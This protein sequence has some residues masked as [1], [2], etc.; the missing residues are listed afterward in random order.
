[1]LQLLSL[2]NYRN[3]HGEWQLQ[4]GANLIIAPN[5]SGKSNLIE[6]IFLLDTNRLLR[7]AEDQSAVIGPKA[8]YTRIRAE[9][10]TFALEMSLT[11]GGNLTKVVKL[12]D[13]KTTPAKLRGKLAS[14]LFAPHSVDLIS[15][16]PAVRRDDLDLFLA[17]SDHHFL[18]ISTKYTKILRNR[19]SLLRQLRDNGGNPH[20]LQYWDENLIDLGTQVYQ[21]RTEFLNEIAELVKQMAEAFYHSEVPALACKYH[22][23]LYEVD[24][25]YGVAMR[26][27]IETNQDKEIAV[28]QSLY[29]PHRD[30]YSFIYNEKDLRLFG[31]RGEQR[32]GVLI[33]KLAQAEYIKQQTANEPLILL[34]DIT[35]ELDDEHR[36]NVAE[37]LLDKGYQFILTA[38]AGE[39]VPQILR[40]K[41]N[42]LNL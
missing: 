15:G 26:A 34:D 5:A 32:L 30:D 22:S 6:S 17:N 11:N 8:E 37:F 16:S 40:A 31:S 3:L 9:T 27:K 36:Q 19:N 39:D 25:D 23:R 41:S 12:N 18:T 35:S 21:A 10:D 4:P 20:D 38:A 28:G 1:M 13:K 33:W 14:V 29:G 2:D 7:L 42:Q 24:P